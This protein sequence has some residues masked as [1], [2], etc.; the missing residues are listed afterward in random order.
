M[1]PPKWH[2]TCYFRRPDH[3]HLPTVEMDPLLREIR[4]SPN[5]FQTAKGLT[6]RKSSAISLDPREDS[7]ARL[8]PSPPTTM[9]IPTTIPL[10]RSPVTSASESDTDASASPLVSPQPHSPYDT[11]R[12]GSPW[13]SAGSTS[14]ASV[15]SSASP[16]TPPASYGLPH[17]HTQH[18][19]T[20]PQ[21]PTYSSYYAHPS[22]YSLHSASVGTTL[23]YPPV[24]SQSHS[25]PT[26]STC[27]GGQGGGYAIY[28][29]P[30]A[31]SSSSS[32]PR[33]GPT[34]PPIRQMVD[35]PRHLP[36]PS[37]QQHQHAGLGMGVQMHQG[38]VTY[39]SS[40]RYG[41]GSGGM[42]YDPSTG[43][44]VERRGWE[45]ER[46]G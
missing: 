11:A 38:T 32:S 17:A 18:A 27:G 19:H 22:H 1:K 28:P 33:E 31:P 45:V 46:E 8:H 14:A 35:M 42:V 16:L 21:Q 20:Q 37:H 2:L 39:A 9:A 41:G 44:Y 7:L 26:Q 6:R 40:E 30:S 23:A 29:P 25:L 24:H 5:T 12:W 3:I 10:H 34:L 36:P 43:Y 13:S 4:P 15:T